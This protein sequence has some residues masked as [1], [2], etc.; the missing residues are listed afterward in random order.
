[1]R[2]H[3]VPAEPRRH[4][5]TTTAGNDGRRPQ[6]VVVGAGAAGS[7]VALPL[8]R[9]AGRRC[10]GIDVVLLDPA[11]RWGRGVAFGTVEDQHLLNVP[12][13][14]RGPLPGARGPFVS[15]PRR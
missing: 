3:Q 14:G 9:T 5:M 11:D 2:R 4:A 15:C 12:A 13:G 10:T 6:V 1:M 8:T 7:L